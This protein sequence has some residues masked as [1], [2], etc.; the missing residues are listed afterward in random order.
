MICVFK[1]NRKKNL[2]HF[3]IFKN[4]EIKLLKIKFLFPF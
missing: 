4:I 1:G 2:F 3:L